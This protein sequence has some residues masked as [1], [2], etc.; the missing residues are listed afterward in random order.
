MKKQLWLGKKMKIAVASYHRGFDL[1]SLGVGVLIGCF[2]VSLTYLTMHNSDMLS[3]QSMASQVSTTADACSLISQR[4]E[5]DG[6]P[7]ISDEFSSNGVASDPAAE[8]EEEEDGFET[9]MCDTSSYRC[10]LCDING[11]VRIV[12]G[13]DSPS[14]LRVAASSRSAA[15]RSWQVKPYARKWDR[16]VMRGIK[17]VDV[18][19][20][21]SGGDAPPCAVAHAAP[22]LVFS[23]GGYAGNYFHDFADV[24]VPLFQSA[25]EFDGE[26]LLV[27]SHLNLWWMA[28]K[29]G[30]YF[31]R[32]SKY[33]PIDLDNDGRVHCF[34][35]AVVGLRADEDLT[36][37][38]G[39]SRAG[40][41]MADFR[42]FMSATYGLN[43]HPAAKI[44]EQPEKKQK[45]PRLL[46]ITRSKSRMFVNADE[47]AQLAE[48]LGFEV[49]TSEA[50]HDVAKFSRVV[51]SCDAMVGVHGAGL[52]NMVFL[53]ANAVVIQVVPFGGHEWIA[54]TYFGNPARGM[55]LKYLEYA[56]DAGEST[57]TELYSRED[58]VFRDPP[59]IHKL[60]WAKMG[61][62][63]LKKQ[64]VRVDLGRFR[65]VLEKALELLRE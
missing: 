26:V 32:I 46:L 23:T 62:I 33:D 39:K 16:A 4:I 14:V 49:V 1:L 65:P 41:T 52:T 3:F 51:N 56:I 42:R 5:P 50:E 58:P 34:S 25:R 35:R 64:N 7:R 9:P 48:Q 18:R 59:A 47:I 63:Y 60:G 61:E 31:R 24:L 38:P 43:R 19:S 55:G 8:E 6:K 27:V 22:A 40:Y 54:T 13:G 15:R 29:Y 12:T 11:D 45:Q 17:P 21:A 20:A 10:D 53:P 57:L 2:I 30:R 36:I 28:G 37:D 44:T